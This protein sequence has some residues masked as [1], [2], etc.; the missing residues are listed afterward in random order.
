MVFMNKGKWRDV[1]EVWPA[2][3]VAGGSFAATQFWVS[4]YIGPELTDIL[5]GVISMASLAGLMLVWKPKKT[6]SS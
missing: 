6:F 2:I 5:G 1:T 3:L 4:N